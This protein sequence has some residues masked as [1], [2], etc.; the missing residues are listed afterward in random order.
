MELG[1]LLK[2]A[3]ILPSS[4]IRLRDLTREL[5][6]H[7]FELN[8]LEQ[9]LRIFLKKELSYFDSLVGDWK[10]QVRASMIVDLMD[11]SESLYQRTPKEIDK[12]S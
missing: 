11:E 4:G 12:V 2:R 5:H 10:C 1:Y 7:L 9:A 3:D 6:V 8:V